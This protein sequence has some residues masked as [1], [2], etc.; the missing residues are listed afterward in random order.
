MKIVCVIPARLESSRFKHKMLKSLNGKPLLQWVWEAAINTKLFSDVVFAIDSKEVED[1]INR[2]NGKSIMT[3][4]SCASGTD[5]LVELFTQKKIEGDIWV[6]WQGDEPF[7]HK[8]MVENLLQTCGSDRAD[9]WTLKKKTSSQEEINNP[10]IAKIVSDHE[11]YVLYFSRSPIPFYRDPSPDNDKIY[12]KH[13]GIY[14]YTQE[15]LKKI[16][17][18]P[19]SVYL[20]EA[21]KLEQLRFL[22]FGLKVRAHETFHD[23]FGIDLPEHLIEAEKRLKST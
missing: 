1:V 2:F 6:N 23:V 20:E 8:E 11:G 22:Y 7:I 16:S 4:K 18:L 5:R 14:A 21:E 19:T 10:N 15:A 13:I 9:I 12:F 3:S 17:N